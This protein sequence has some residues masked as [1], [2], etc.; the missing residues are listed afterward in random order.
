MAIGDLPRLQLFLARGGGR[1]LRNVDRLR[2]A[3]INRVGSRG[4]NV[5][6][7]QST[8]SPPPGDSRVSENSVHVEALKEK[9]DLALPYFEAFGTQTGVT[10]QSLLQ[11]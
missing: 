8:G 11:K 5:I 2:F 3:A 9:K 4:A 1:L 7:L 10:G 6:L